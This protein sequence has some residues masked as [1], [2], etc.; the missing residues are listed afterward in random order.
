MNA[1]SCVRPFGGTTN[2]GSPVESA[3]GAAVKARAPGYAVG[4]GTGVGVG[5]RASAPPE[6]A[7]VP[8]VI[9]I[10]APEPAHD[11]ML[12]KKR[13]SVS[14]PL[15]SGEYAPTPWLIVTS[16]SCGTRA[17]VVGG[18]FCACVSDVPIRLP[19]S[20]SKTTIETRRATR[21]TGASPDAATSYPLDAAGQ[22][23]AE[24][25]TV[26]PGNKVMRRYANG[27]YRGYE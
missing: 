19:T 18:F 26:R 20:T 16:R 7:S 24:H 10:E 2:F 3:I 15:T 4:E 27:A 14:L 17:H 23:L 9:W 6:T 25:T 13:T 8:P 12:R 5:D 11:G 1:P 21:A 22:A